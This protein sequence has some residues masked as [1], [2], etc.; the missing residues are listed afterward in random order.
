MTTIKAMKQALH[1]LRWTHFGECRTYP[2]PVPEAR[3]VDKLLR[4]AIAAEEAQ[5]VARGR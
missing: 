2:G 4:E 5:G 3:E 1:L